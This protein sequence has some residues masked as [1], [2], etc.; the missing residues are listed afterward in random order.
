MT[1]VVCKVSQFLYLFIL[2]KI[3]S[4]QRNQSLFGEFERIPPRF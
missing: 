3:K 1:D 2:M 4:V